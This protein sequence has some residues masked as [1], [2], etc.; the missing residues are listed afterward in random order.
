ML[1]AT[2]GCGEGKD[3]PAPDPVAQAGLRK[4]ALDWLRADLSL[5]ARQLDRGTD[6]DRK[7]VCAQLTHWRH[8]A[9]LSGVRDAEALAKLHETEQMAWRA[10]WA[11]VNALV[12]QAQSDH[13]EPRGP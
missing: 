6:A 7:N 8:E 10:F 5:G 9:D 12:K 3:H 2:A 4:Q 13:P 11:D 1:R